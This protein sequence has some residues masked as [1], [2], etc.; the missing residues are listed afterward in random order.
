[1]PSTARGRGRAERPA[2]EDQLLK[3]RPNFFF[4]D[5]CFKE[6]ENENERL[7]RELDATETYRE[8]AQADVSG[9]GE[10]LRR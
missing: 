9:C 5:Q 4:K 3:H 1:M 2:E 6:L 10:E 7:Q 8:L